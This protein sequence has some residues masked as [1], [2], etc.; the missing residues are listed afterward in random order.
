MKPDDLSRRAPLALFLGAGDLATAAGR[1]LRLAGFEVVYLESERPTALRRGVAFAAAVYEGS[2]TVEGVTAVLVPGPLEAREIL[3]RGD[4]AVLVDPR[5]A[6]LQAFRPD[7]LVDG[8]MTKGREPLFPT[9]T[10]AAPC[11]IGLGPGFVAGRDVHAV[12]ET[13]RG[14]DLGR[15]IV[16]GSALPDSGV[17][18]IVAGLGEPRV[19]RSPADGVFIPLRAIGDLVSEG[20][21]V[22]EVNGVPVRAATGGVIRGLLHGGLRVAR[23]RKVGDVDPRGEPA[24]CSRISDKAHAVAEGVLRALPASLVFLERSLP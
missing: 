6:S 11:V 15:V 23:G 4:I 1:R 22:A 14:P 19:L 17:P 13:C 3:A 5:A 20:E 2:I 12:V 24:L 18:G 9:T 10:V 7:V 21:T 8:R 16:E